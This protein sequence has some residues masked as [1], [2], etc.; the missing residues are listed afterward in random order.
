MMIGMNERPIVL[1]NLKYDVDVGALERYASTEEAT[2]AASDDPSEPRAALTE[3]EMI[4]RFLHNVKR[5][6]DGKGTCT[7]SYTR[8]TIGQAL[9][10]AQLLQ[11][12]RIYPDNW[13]S[14]ATQLGKRLRSLALGKY[15][16]EADD[17]HAFHK[18]VQ[19]LTINPEARELIERIVTDASLKVELSKHYFADEAHTTEVK[20]LLHAMSNGGAVGTWRAKH[21]VGERSRI[22]IL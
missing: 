21:R 15:Y 22:T 13:P 1:S 7:V 14:C 19:S 8:C 3:R 17:E 20:Q 10:D 9:V 12:T 4:E 18:L 16:D 2:R 6:K 5:D 11:H